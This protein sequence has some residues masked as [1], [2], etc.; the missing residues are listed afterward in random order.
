MFKHIGGDTIATVKFRDLNTNK[1]ITYR[2]MDLNNPLFKEAAT[3]YNDIEKLK[4]T[5]I[6]DPIIQVKQ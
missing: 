3:V 4:D 6:D 5:K 1:I 2:N